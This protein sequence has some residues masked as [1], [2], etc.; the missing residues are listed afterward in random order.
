MTKKTLE[1]ALRDAI[2][3]VLET[4]FFSSLEFTEAP[5]ATEWRA[6]RRSRMYAC[7]LEFS[8]PRRGSLT[9]HIPDLAL[10]ALTAGFMGIETRDVTEDHLAGTIR[11]LANMITGNLFA[12]HDPE[13]VYTLGIPAIIPA[14]EEPALK[15]RV[16]SLTYFISTTEG[17]LAVIMTNYELGIT[18]QE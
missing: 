17:P 11:E 15:D 12:I 6:W 8:G 4:M 7:R 5:V 10:T 14:A 13:A 2:S 18:N 3:K 16:E 9:V 1:T